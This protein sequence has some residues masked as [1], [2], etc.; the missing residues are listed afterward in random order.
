MSARDTH[1]TQ[2]GATVQTLLDK[3]E[4]LGPATQDADGLMSK[5]D[6]EKLDDGVADRPL[7]NL[8]IEAI[9]NS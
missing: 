4:D 5:S 3:I 7:T 1:L 8:E 9:L 2:P 6:K